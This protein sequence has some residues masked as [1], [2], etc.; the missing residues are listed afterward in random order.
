M[1]GRAGEAAGRMVRN[2]PSG[3]RRW[4]AVIG[5]T[6]KLVGAGAASYTYAQQISWMPLVFLSCVVFGVFLE[7]LSIVALAEPRDGWWKNAGRNVLDEAL[8]VMML[9]MAAV[10]PGGLSPHGLIAVLV[11]APVVIAIVIWLTLGRERAFP[12]L[13]RINADPGSVEG[14]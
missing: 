12:T 6:V 14:C 13:A 10:L 11:V 5:W 1:M 7:Q 9:A 2:M 8:P 3:F 4:M